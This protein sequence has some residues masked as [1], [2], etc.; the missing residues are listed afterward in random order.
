[1][2]SSVIPKTMVRFSGASADVLPCHLGVLVMWIHISWDGGRADVWRRA[3]RA[4]INT[5]AGLQVEFVDFT[6]L[7]RSSSIVLAL[8][9]TKTHLGEFL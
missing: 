3:M 7:G 2:G 6:H 5:A 1:M 9:D 4:E 8:H